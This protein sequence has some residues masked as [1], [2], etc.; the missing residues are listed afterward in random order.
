MSYG[1]FM[2]YEKGTNGQ[3]VIAEK[4]VDEILW[5]A[6]N[7]R[8]AVYEGKRVVVS[9]KINLHRRQGCAERANLVF[10]MGSLANVARRADAEGLL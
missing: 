5:A 6:M 9:G 7:E 4:A 2:G 1:C 3:A 8:M 10:C